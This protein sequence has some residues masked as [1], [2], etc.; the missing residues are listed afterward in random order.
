MSGSEQFPDSPDPRE[1]DLDQDAPGELDRAV[2]QQGD[3]KPSEHEEWTTNMEASLRKDGVAVIDWTIDGRPGV[4]FVADNREYAFARVLNLGFSI[5]WTTSDSAAE[6]IEKCKVLGRSGTTAIAICE[7]KREVELKD[8]EIMPFLQENACWWVM[9]RRD[10]LDD[11]VVFAAGVDDRPNELATTGP[12]LVKDAEDTRNR[13]KHVRVMMKETATPR[14]KELDAVADALI[15][16]VETSA[17]F[18][19]SAFS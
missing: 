13:A 11:H 17:D 14:L 18:A 3:L 4:K 12:P 1:V 16:R 9:V 19:A 7:D 15:E 2:S 5:S 6:A 10:D 8:D